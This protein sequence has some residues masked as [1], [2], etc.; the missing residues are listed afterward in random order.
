LRADTVAA[1]ATATADTTSTAA[2]NTTATADATAA[3][4]LQG[5]ESNYYTRAHSS[6]QSAARDEA[7]WLQAYYRC[8][9][10]ATLT[11]LS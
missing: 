10:A 2:A 11:I 5:A 6:A 3:T 9:S 7:E 8:V 1:T 4:M